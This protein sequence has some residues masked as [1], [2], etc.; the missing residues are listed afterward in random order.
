MKKITLFFGII[1][2]STLVVSCGNTNAASKI[3]KENVA[4]AS[5]RDIEIK[6]GSASASFD[7]TVYDFGTI[8]EGDV[9]ETTFVITN[10]G[11]TDLVITNA[12]TSCGCTIPKWPK[13]AIKPGETGDIQVKFNSRGKRN[14]ISKSITLTTN[15]SKGRETVRIKGFVT[16]KKKTNP[17]KK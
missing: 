7:K 2:L 4:K 16:P 6:K 3:K 12:K 8:N 1:A 14:N 9:I 17:I 11:K 10:T 15:T 5:K 13:E